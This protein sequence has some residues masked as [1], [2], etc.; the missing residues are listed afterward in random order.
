M[1][2]LLQGFNEHELIHED[3]ESYGDSI[4]I[5]L[6]NNTTLR[7]YERRPGVLELNSTSVLHI[8]PRATNLVHIRLDQDAFETGK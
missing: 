1:K 7:L 2:V 6:R 8:E 5:V 3:P 4:L